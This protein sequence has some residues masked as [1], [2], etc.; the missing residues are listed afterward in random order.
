MLQ[1]KFEVTDI[2]KCGSFGFHLALNPPDQ[3][4][5]ERG[6]IIEFCPDMADIKCSLSS[7]WRKVKLARYF[8]DKAIKKP[9]ACMG[10]RLRY[11]RVCQET[12]LM[13]NLP[14]AD[15]KTDILY[16][17]SLTKLQLKTAF[18]YRLD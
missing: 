15:L 17:L 5:I 16:R 12:T 1:T 10:V 18:S 7:M 6:F 11:V 8:L 4:Q 2:F 9:N 13:Q 3:L 14:T